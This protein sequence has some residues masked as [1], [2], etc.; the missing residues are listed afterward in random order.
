MATV[1]DVALSGR[2]TSSPANG[3]GLPPEDTGFPGSTFQSFKPGGFYGYHEKCAENR[4]GHPDCTC[5]YSDHF[6]RFSDRI[7]E[8]A[9]YPRRYFF[10]AYRPC[11][12]LTLK[13][14][15]AEG[16][17]QKITWGSSSTRHFSR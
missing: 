2:K 13:R 15:R 17:Q 12:V 7:L 8:A 14:T 1:I 3:I 5:D 9:I 16:L 6:G 11:R 4:E 10:G